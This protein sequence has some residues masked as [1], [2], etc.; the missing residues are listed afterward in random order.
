M[1]VNPRRI[2]GQYHRGL[3]SGQ[4][5]GQ[6]W[7][8]CSAVKGQDGNHPSDAGCLRLRD[9]IRGQN[10]ALSATIVQAHLL[11]PS[12][13]HGRAMDP[14]FCARI[15]GD[16]CFVFRILLLKTPPCVCTG[17]FPPHR[18]PKH[19]LQRAFSHHD[20]RLA[21]LSGWWETHLEKSR[22]C[23]II[24]G[25]TLPGFKPIRRHHLTRDQ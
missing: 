3:S 11:I 21:W 8:N 9:S 13:S 17:M 19:P 4:W 12:F 10:P 20:G 25:I 6:A 22:I 7:R 5:I 24:R 23:A 18:L 1:R 2:G 15:R 14:C 16:M